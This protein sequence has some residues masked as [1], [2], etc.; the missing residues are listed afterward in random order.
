MTMA[1]VGL[2]DEPADDAQNENETCEDRYRKAYERGMADG[3]GLPWVFPGGPYAQGDLNQAL[4][5]HR[6]PQ[7]RP[8]ENLS[9]IAAG[10]RAF[11]RYLRARHDEARFWAVGH[12]RHFARWVTQY[13]L[14]KLEQKS[15]TRL[16]VV[17]ARPQLEPKPISAVDMLASLTA[18]RLQ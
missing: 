13:K 7:K 8:A 4:A 10:A 17:E 5:L 3:L 2:F 18:L 11:G 1:D 9:W 16:R 6:G 12:P 14:E 15:G